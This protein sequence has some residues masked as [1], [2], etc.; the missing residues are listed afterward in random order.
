MGTQWGPQYWGG[1]TEMPM[2]T[3]ILGGGALRPQM[4]SLILGWGH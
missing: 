2:G 1:D 4:G 3:L